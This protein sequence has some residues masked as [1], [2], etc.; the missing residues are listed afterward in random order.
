MMAGTHKGIKHGQGLGNRIAQYFSDNPHEELTYSDIAAK[1]SATERSAY[2]RVSEL[3]LD[4]TLETVTVIRRK[5][6]P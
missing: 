1:F 4:G 3:C 2:S 5:S 6:A